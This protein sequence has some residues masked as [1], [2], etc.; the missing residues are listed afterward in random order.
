MFHPAGLWEY[1]CEFLL[2]NS[3]NG[4]VNV[5]QNGPGTGG[6]LIQCEDVFFHSKNLRQDNKKGKGFFF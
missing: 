4:S 3:G 2:G 1:L 5:E 6:A